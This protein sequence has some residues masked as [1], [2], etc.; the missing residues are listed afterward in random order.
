MA[1]NVYRPAREGRSCEHFGGNKTINGNIETHM[2]KMVGRC[3]AN[4]LKE[5]LLSQFPDIKT[6]KVQGVTKKCNPPL[7]PF[8]LQTS[9]S[10]IKN[11]FMVKETL[12]LRDKQL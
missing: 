8:F 5:R 3:T 2:I 4:R 7:F 12:Y 11:D 10:N 9:L 6:A 1:F